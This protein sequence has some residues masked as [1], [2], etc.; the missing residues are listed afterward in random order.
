[1]SDR[2][3]HVVVVVGNKWW[4]GG[5]RAGIRGLSYTKEVGSRER[6]LVVIGVVIVFTSLDLCEY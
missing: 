5:R 2:K 6:V 3:I 1:M 4:Y